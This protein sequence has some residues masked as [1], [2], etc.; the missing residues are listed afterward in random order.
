MTCVFVL[1]LALDDIVVAHE[2]KPDPK[3]VVVVAVAVEV[4]GLELFWVL[5][6]RAAWTYVGQ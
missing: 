4:S 1:Y 2:P 5:L 6:R 3:P